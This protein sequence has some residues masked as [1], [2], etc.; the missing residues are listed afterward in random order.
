MYSWI[1][2]INPVLYRVGFERPIEHLSIVD[3]CDKF[4]Y[5]YERHWLTCSIYNNKGLIVKTIN[6]IKS[7]NTEISPKYLTDADLFLRMI[8]TIRKP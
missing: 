1:D 3:I 6:N 5:S 4:S 7:V 8:N 2:N